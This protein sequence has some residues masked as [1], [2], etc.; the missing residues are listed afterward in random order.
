MVRQPKDLAEAR[1]IYR[2]EKAK[3]TSSV[4]AVAGSRWAMAILATLVLAFGTHLAFAPERLPGLS[5]FNLAS[6]GLPPNL[7]FGFAGEQAKEAAEAARNSEAGDRARNFVADKIPL[8]NAIAFGATLLLL[9]V[10]MWVMTR[11]R[12]VS[13]G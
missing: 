10:N 13:R 11:R 8:I 5:G 6:T 7:D 2:E 9:L 4:S 1:E 3:L 12:R